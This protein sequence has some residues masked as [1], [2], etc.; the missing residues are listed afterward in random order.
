MELESRRFIRSV[1]MIA[2]VAPKAR[3]CF[4]SL[5]VGSKLSSVRVAVMSTSLPRKPGLVWTSASADFRDDHEILGVRMERLLDELI[6]HMGSVV[7]AGIDVVHAG[8]YRLSQNSNGGIHIL[9]R[10]PNA[11]A[12]QLHGAVAHAVQF[13][14]LTGQSEAAR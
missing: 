12:S 4:S 1:R 9:R 14:R 7:V 2:M 8:L 6:G 13:Y 3:N 5:S 10:S 11:R